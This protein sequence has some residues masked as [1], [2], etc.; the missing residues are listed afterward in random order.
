M[1]QETLPKALA[2]RAELVLSSAPCAL[3][4]P[5]GTGKTHL[6]GA[7]VASA[8][9][10]G[11]RSLILTH[12]NAGVDA[13]RKRLS[14]FGVAASDY[15]ID[16]ITSWAFTLV[17][18]YKD[19]AEVL[20]PKLPDWT[21][22]SL[23]IA[24]ATRVAQASAIREMHRR[25]FDF[26]FVDEYQDCNA[27]QHELLLAISAAIPKT[28][29]LGDRLQGIFGFNEPLV[30]WET[31][32]FDHFPPLNFEH[33]PHRWTDTNPD[34]GAWLLGIRPQMKHG[35][36]IDFSE[37][38]P[39][40]VRWVNLEKSAIADAAYL[41]R[42]YSETV[43]VLDKWASDVA[44]HAS[45]LGG[46]FSVMEDIQGRFMLE[47]LKILPNNNSPFLAAWLAQ[48]SKLCIVGLADL[49]KPILDALRANRSLSSFQRD[50]ITHV[51]DALEQLRLNPSYQNLAA[52]AR[53]IPRK[54][55]ARV[56]RWEAWNDT[57]DAIAHSS[58]AT[59]PLY[60]FGLIRDRIRRTG[61]RSHSRIASR[62]L[63]V[64]GLEY[65][66][67]IIADVSKLRD[68]RNL[69]VAM[70]RARRT[71]TIIGSN[72]TVSLWYD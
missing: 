25:S 69:Y 2:E 48:F 18:A 55:V 51:L 27:S 58:T 45:R 22:S 14:S 9:S 8:A 49:N 59:T 38:L 32:V 19:I 35:N 57:I 42:N 13:M 24:A 72:S 63:L 52:V 29:V 39:A 21:S 60:E 37:G 26:L 7:A 70:S 62:T 10:Q 56:Y 11:K 67:V 50:G 34:L 66:H 36:T 43:L 6:L 16:T 47:Q 20:V 44:I 33:V 41:F 53:L 3:E 40:G 65:D 68:P 54:H 15:R 12:T 23:Y 71:L 31:D 5:A 4:M 28:I 1:D 46:S 30:D 17:R 64:K 61:R